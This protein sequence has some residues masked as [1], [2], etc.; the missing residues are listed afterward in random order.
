MVG[1]FVGF[2]VT[3]FPCWLNKTPQKITEESVINNRHEPRTIFFNAGTTIFQNA[4]QDYVSL[5]PVGFS[6]PSEVFLPLVLEQFKF[7]EVSF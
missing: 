2:L 6:V 1:G 7:C 5:C 3:F 4:V